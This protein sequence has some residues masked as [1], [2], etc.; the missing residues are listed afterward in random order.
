MDRSREIYSTPNP[1]GRPRWLPDG[2]GL[3]A[4]IGNIDQALRGQLWFI[5]FP[6]GQARRLTNDLMDYQPCCLDLTQDG[7]TLVDTEGRR[8]SDLWIAPAR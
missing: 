3:L 4:P 7:R 8:V 2:S 5:S 6:R 1:I